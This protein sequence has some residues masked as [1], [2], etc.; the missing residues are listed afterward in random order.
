[1]FGTSP[2]RAVDYAILCKFNAVSFAREGSGH[3]QVHR[4][5]VG[6]IPP[7]I[8]GLNFSFLLLVSWL[9]FFS[10][11]LSV[12]WTETRVFVSVFVVMVDTPVRKSHDALV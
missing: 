12:F 9:E 11:S 5:A 8:N 2:Q 3:H 4:K 6:C 1:M 10:H 7:D